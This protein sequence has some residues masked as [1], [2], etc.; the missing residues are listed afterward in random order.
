MGIDRVLNSICA[1]CHE[2]HDGLCAGL[3]D[4]VWTG[5]IH[6]KP[7]H[8]LKIQ[9]VRPQTTNYTPSDL[10]LAWA[11][12]NGGRI[13]YTPYGS[14]R[15]LFG[16]RAWEYERMQ[17]TPNGDGTNTVTVHLLRDNSFKGGKI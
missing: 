9:L 13:D 14:I 15:L 11:R 8:M 12:E 2:F 1:A 16:G 4:D 7:D 17:H 3:Y 6:R 10:I 5:C